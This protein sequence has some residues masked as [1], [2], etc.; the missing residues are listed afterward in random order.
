MSIQY[1]YINVRRSFT[2]NSPN[3]TN[4]SAPQQMNGETH[5]ASSIQWNTTQQPT[6]MSCW[7]TRH[8]G[9]V[10]ELCCIEET[11]EKRVHNVWFHLYKILERAS[12]SPVTESRP[13]NRSELWAG[14]RRANHKGAQET[15]LWWWQA[16]SSSQLRWG[17]RVWVHMTPLPRLLTWNLCTEIVHVSLEGIR[18]CHSKIRFF[19]ILVI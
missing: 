9:W 10:S 3:G 8:Y 17:V 6:G 15:K 2:S 7:Y 5:G 16:R 12:S 4:P 19:G 11:G 14:E 13:G 18:A 1:W